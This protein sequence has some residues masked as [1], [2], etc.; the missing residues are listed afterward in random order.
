M[1]KDILCNGNYLVFTAKQQQWQSRQQIFALYAVKACVA[2]RCPGYRNID[3]CGKHQHKRCKKTKTFLFTQAVF[4]CRHT[5]AGQYHHKED[6]KDE[7]I[8]DING[9]IPKHPAKNTFKVVCAVFKDCVYK[10]SQCNYR[11][12]QQ[13]TKVKGCIR[14]VYQQAFKAFTSI[15]GPCYICPWKS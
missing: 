3:N 5:A 14:V 2:Y 10:Q 12:L 1:V 9:V 13:Q 6:N 7:C 11:V 4:I 15:K 8:A